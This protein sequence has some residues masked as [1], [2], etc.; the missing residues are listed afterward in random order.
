M[1]TLITHMLTKLVFTRSCLL[2]VWTLHFSKG[3]NAMQLISRAGPYLFLAAIVI[4]TYIAL[5]SG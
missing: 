4:S 5:K 1:C 3:T 2:E